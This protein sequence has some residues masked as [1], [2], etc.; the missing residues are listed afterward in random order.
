MAST[1][2][3][4]PW[5]GIRIGSWCACWYT[6]G[7]VFAAGADFFFGEMST[8]T[9]PFV[10]NDAWKLMWAASWMIERFFVVRFRVLRSAVRW[11][12]IGCMSVF[13][14]VSGVIGS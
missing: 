1:L 11:R 14:M 13:V 2:E 12:R 4:G 3:A 10:P 5:A 6:G 8:A 9:F 7:C